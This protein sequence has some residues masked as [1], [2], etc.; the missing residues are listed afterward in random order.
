MTP[1]PQE[2]CLDVMDGETG[3][4]DGCS[5]GSCSGQDHRATV[6]K[7]SLA[8]TARGL[9]NLRDRDRINGKVRDGRGHEVKWESWMIPDRQQWWRPGQTVPM[10]GRW[11]AGA[12]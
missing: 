5:D 11:H 8:G 6:A 4:C 3:E 10:E 7:C 1:L 12:I 9:A 2:A